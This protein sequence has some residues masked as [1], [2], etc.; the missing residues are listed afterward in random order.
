MRF[1]FQHT[2]GRPAPQIGFAWWWKRRRMAGRYTA[3]TQR[4]LD[5][6][7]AGPEF[8]LAEK[9][10][11]HLYT[12]FVIMMYGSTMPLL[13]VIGAIHFAS[14]FWAEKFELLRVCKRPLSYSN[15]L[16]TY[17]S[18]TMPFAALW[19]LAMAIW[20]YSL[21]G[22]AESPVVA[23]GFRKSLTSTL[24]V[25]DVLMA[26][27]SN[28]TPRLV[29]WR[30]TQ[31]SSGHLFIAFLLAGAVLFLFFTL[32]AWIR[33]MRW[34]ASLLGCIRDT[35]DSDERA[36][37]SDPGSGGSPPAPD[38]GTAVRT[39]LLVGPD[40]YDIQSN[41][42]Y[43]FA[44]A[45]MEG[46]QWAAPEEGE[47][48][49]GSLRPSAI[50]G[51]LGLTGTLPATGGDGGDA[52]GGGG[53]PRRASKRERT[54]AARI[55]AR[56]QVAAAAAAANWGQAT[57]THRLS[58]PS[59]AV[60]VNVTA[61]ASSSGGGYGGGNNKVVPEPTT[62]PAQQLPPPDRRPSQPPPPPAAVDGSPGLV[63]SFSS[64][65]DGGANAYGV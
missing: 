47:D 22:T 55:R 56:R 17:A 26:R 28:L 9:Y 60:A 20:A 31:N 11:M 37:G 18:S 7:F 15:D 4:Q 46:L 3:L 43:A 24:E 29:G 13:Y 57:K 48:K 63:S 19:H 38:F 6:A 50:A 41:P 62:P 27:A 42:A 65:G 40:T 10:G 58:N 30:L 36:A 21:F 5:E 12:L 45:E 51:G 35:G 53:R 16:A 52:G 2:P 49:L 59:G 54:S 33:A 44:F 64:P 25:F 8:L 32:S 23:S 39:A 14:C 34:L 1:P 61:N